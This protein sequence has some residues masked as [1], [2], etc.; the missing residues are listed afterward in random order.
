M[1]KKKFITVIG[2]VILIVGI[3]AGT[4]LVQ[5]NQ[6]FRERAAPA[7]SVYISPSSQNKNPGSSFTFTVKMDTGVN[8]ITG[9]D[10][11]L[12]FDPNLIEIVSIEKNAGISALDATIT[13]TFSNTTGKIS[14]AVYTANK[15]NAVTGSSVGILTVNGTVKSGASGTASISFDPATVISGVDEGVNVIINMTPGSIIIES[16]A[17]TSSSQATATATSTSAGI[18][19]VSVSSAIATPTRTATSVSANNSSATSTPVPVP[20]TGNS[21]TTFLGVGFGFMVILGSLF[22]VF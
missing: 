22:L 11:R 14:F 12:N 17:S 20:V 18:G 3:I 1:N 9:V 5:N 13:N 15:A 21:L 19:G 2:S 10:V 16:S 8:Q 7:T 4:I 6:D